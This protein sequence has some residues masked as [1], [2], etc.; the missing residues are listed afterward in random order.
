MTDADKP[1]VVILNDTSGRS[2]HGCSRVM[3]LLVDGLQRHGLQIIARSPARHDWVR[4]AAFLVQ[5]KQANLIVV[6]GEG[7]L[8][9]GRPA[10]QRLLEVTRHPGARAPV[11]VINALWQ[12]N[13]AD[14]AAMLGKCAL[15]SARDSRSQAAMRAAGVSAR[16]V[17]D[18]SLTGGAVLQ[19]SPRNGLIVGDSVRLST[20][21]QLARAAARLNARALLPTK[22]RQSV[23]YRLPLVRAVVSAAYN[24]VVPCTTP[25][26]M[27]AADEPAYLAELGR[28]QMH[29]T[30]R[31]HAICLSIVTQTPFLA[32]GSNSWKIEALLADAGLPA[33]RLIPLETLATLTEAAVDRPFAEAETA[34]IAAFLTRA[35]TD[36]EA[37][38]ADLAALAQQDRL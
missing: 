3:R 34:G 26:L 20:R 17:P 7:T 16:L 10:G 13:P 35:M 29:L 25:P 15:V 11:A 19:S 30:G 2:H 36:A 18:L 1:R 33:D 4:D 28:A 27:L 37:L 9:H 14:W 24:G 5:L 22:T 6:N 8:H 12:D 21:R 23:L 32:V 31:F 38:F